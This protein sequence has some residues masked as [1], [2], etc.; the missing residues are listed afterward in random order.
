[1]NVVL[2]AEEAAGLQMLR[3]LARSNHQLVAVLATPPE[4]GATAASVWSVARTSGFQTWPAKMVKDPN[5]ADR[6]RSERV[7]ILLNVHSLYIIHRDVLAA[8]LLGAFNLHPGPLPRYA[9]LNAVSWAICRGEETHGV[10][11]H[12]I[13]PGIDTGPIAY[14][15]FFPIENSATGLS[16]SFK[17]MR[18]GIRLMLN[19]LDSASIE[20]SRIPL[21]SQDLRQR[22][23]F[24][25]EVPNNG[26][27]TWSSPAKRVVNFV[28]ACD[29]LPFR[30]PWG[31]P[32]TQLRDRE[33]GV[34][35]AK[36][37]G[38]PCDA[39]PGTVGRPFDSGV[40]VACLD[41]WVLVKQLKID[42]Q[43][44]NAADVLRPG[45][46]LGSETYNRSSYESADQFSR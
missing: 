27:L 22:E 21:L 7:D 26:W 5:L 39:L 1:M 6:L 46:H 33:L 20:P 13:E 40:Q 45:D 23:Y 32:K 3:A 28:R 11:I 37:T 16:L 25:G 2:A 9:G 8:P 41:E 34:V 31:C 29:Y 4:P 43:Y 12:K 38:L 14:Q 15:S 10:T 42:D 19:L 30:S 18:E 17:C 35:K 36:A 24:G 44:V